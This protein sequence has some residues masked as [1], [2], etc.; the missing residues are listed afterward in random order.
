[1]QFNAGDAGLHAFMYQAVFLHR[2]AMAGRQRQDEMVAVESFQDCS[3]LVAGKAFSLA[4]KPG[5]FWSPG[6]RR[7]NFSVDGLLPGMHHY[8][9]LQTI[10]CNMATIA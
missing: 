6:M 8:L 3:I 10:Y 1:M 4:F 5:L 2:K 7:Q 9:R